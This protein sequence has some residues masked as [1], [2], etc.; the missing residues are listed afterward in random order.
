MFTHGNSCGGGN[1][2]K[3]AGIAFLRAHLSY[4]DNECLIWPMFR[5]P[6]GYGRVGY[7][8]VQ[9]WAHRLMCELVHGEAPSPA[10]EASH[11]CGKGHEGCVNPKHLSWKTRAENQADRYAHR[12][13]PLRPDRYRLTEQHIAEIRALGGKVK[14]KELAARY[15]TSQGNIRQILL[16]Q[17]WKNGKAGLRGFAA[18][19]R[20]KSPPLTS[21]LCPGNQP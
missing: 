5:D 9:C 19:R 15:D 12:R 13:K 3:G 8:G 21:A 10:H 18:T 2:G 17:T 20:P 7:L 4:A 11:N 1:R 14:T 16:G 6:N